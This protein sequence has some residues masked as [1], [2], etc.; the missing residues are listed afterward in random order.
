MAPGLRPTAYAPGANR[1]Y[2]CAIFST[3]GIRQRLSRPIGRSA[4]RLRSIAR[5][6]FVGYRFVLRCH[7]AWGVRSGAPAGAK[8]RPRAF[9]CLA[10]PR[11]LLLLL[12]GHRRPQGVGR[13]GAGSRSGPPP[14]APSFVGP[15]P[16]LSPPRG[17]WPRPATAVGA[18]G[19]RSSGLNAPTAFLS[20]TALFST[21]FFNF[22]G[23]R[24]YGPRPTPAAVGLPPQK[25]KKKIYRKS[26]APENLPRGLRPRGPRWAQDKTQSKDKDTFA[27]GCSRTARRGCLPLAAGRSPSVFHGVLRSRA[28]GR[29]RFWGLMWVDVPAPPL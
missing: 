5:A 27:V 18:S 6:L 20:A 23:A 3:A 24:P 11:A 21:N 29:P 15:P 13:T 12:L 10:L 17:R 7:V 25:N 2:G 8:D 26:C 19:E 28:S 1:H 4:Q 9:V 14:R 16:L 22:F